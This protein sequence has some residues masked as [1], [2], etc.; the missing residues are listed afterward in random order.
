FLLSAVT[1]AFFLS[2]IS[3][4]CAADTSADEQRIKKI[5]QTRVRVYGTTAVVTAL[6]SIIARLGDERLNERYSWTDVFVK[7]DGEWKRVA[8]HVSMVGQK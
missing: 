7:Q 6:G 1:L 3:R 4:A 5:D 2:P 8:G